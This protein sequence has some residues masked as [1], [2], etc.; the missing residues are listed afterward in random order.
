MLVQ[1][2]VHPYRGMH[3]RSGFGLRGSHRGILCL[4]SLTGSVSADS[5]CGLFHRHRWLK[6][7]VRRGTLAESDHCTQAI[8]VL[9]NC[10]KPRRRVSLPGQ[11]ARL[12]WTVTSGP[13]TTRS[14][15]KMQTSS[16]RF[17]R[18]AATRISSESARRSNR[19]GPTEHGTAGDF[20]KAAEL[21]LAFVKQHPMIPSSTSCTTIRRFF[22][23]GQGC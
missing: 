11:S 18:S 4:L 8:P 7:S 19:V 23:S 17:R 9:R 10:G 6:S 22:G 15:S 2:S 5:V 13:R 3:N 14:L 20:R 16:A 21:A 1:R 12:L